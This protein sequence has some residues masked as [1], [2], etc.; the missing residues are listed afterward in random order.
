MMFRFLMGLALAACVAVAARRFRSLSTGGAVVATCL[1]GAALSA[2]W[3][4][5]A[6]LIVYFV[7]STLLSRVG[8][9]EKEARTSAI[10]A[11]GGE[12]DAV[13]VLANGA[14]FAGA[15]L[16]THWLPNATCLALA[17]GSLAASTA[18]TWATE[19]GTLVGG[20]PRSI[21]T[22]KR[23]AVG[24]SGGVSAA[25]L[26]A[27]VAGAAF[28]AFCALA[29]GWPNGLIRFVFVGGI[30]GA[31]VDSLLG[32]TLQARRWCEACAMETER[33]IHRCG[34]GTTPRRGVAWLDN[35]VVNFLSNAAGGLL[36]ALLIRVSA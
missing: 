24:T 14:L 34:T 20:E 2:G 27:S 4:W 11:K 8:R 22:G 25:G 17:A 31:L 30:V 16:A 18:D 15:A 36:A 1:G 7:A 3:G 28:I 21:L 6:L 29:F 12:R 23:V 26:L 13:Q 9:T 10:V 32:A 33:T 19:V 35:D 5:G